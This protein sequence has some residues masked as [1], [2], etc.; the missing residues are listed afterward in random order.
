MNI[1]LDKKE[2]R[3]IN[4][5]CD[6]FMSELKEDST[7]ENPN[8]NKYYDLWDIRNKIMNKILR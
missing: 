4:E 5:A 8:T 7:F 6:F 3:L 2:I 1:E